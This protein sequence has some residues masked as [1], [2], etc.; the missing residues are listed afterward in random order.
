MKLRME[1]WMD[2]RGAHADPG[3]RRVL[4]SRSLQAM[5]AG[6]IAPLSP[7]IPALRV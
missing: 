1:R 4:K 5:Q 6:Q 3:C 2:G 7:E